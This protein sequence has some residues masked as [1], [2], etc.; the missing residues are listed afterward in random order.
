MSKPFIG[1]DEWLKELERISGKQGDQQALTSEEICEQLNIADCTARKNI[2]K[3]GVRSGRIV[4]TKKLI[5][6]INGQRRLVDAYR[7]SQSADTKTSDQPNKDKER[8]R[9]RGSS[10]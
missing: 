8:G 5:T 2:L 7:L 4:H 1:I 10:V 3:P 6:Q 9:K